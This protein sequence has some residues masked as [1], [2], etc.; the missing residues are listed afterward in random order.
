MPELQNISP[1]S[2]DN[3]ASSSLLWISASGKWED[4]GETKRALTFPENLLWVRKDGSP[5]RP[6]HLAASYLPSAFSFPLSFNPPHQLELFLKRNPDLIGPESKSSRASSRDSIQS[7]QSL[8]WQPD[9]HDLVPGKHLTTSQHQLHS[10]QDCLCSEQSTF[11]SSM[12]FFMKTFGDIALSVQIHSGRTDIF[13]LL[14]NSFHPGLQHVSIDSGHSLWPS[15]KFYNC[16]H[17]NL[18]YF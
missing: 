2:K 5:C 10:P 9:L 11:T 7:S 1:L 15:V 4:A 13:K 3:C 17:I 16:L 12:L 18:A 14:I 8:V 6:L